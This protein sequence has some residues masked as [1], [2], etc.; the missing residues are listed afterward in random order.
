MGMVIA[1]YY[2]DHG[3]AHFHVKYGNH[4]AS[5]AIE[6]LEVL[7]GSLPQ[8]VFGLVLEWAFQHRKELGKLGSRQNGETT[9]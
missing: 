8:R 4:E 5:I 6:T 9:Q 3:P 7:E 1:I 2:R